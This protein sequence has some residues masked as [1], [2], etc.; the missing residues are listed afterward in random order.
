MIQHCHLPRRLRTPDLGIPAMNHLPGPFVHR[1]SY[2]LLFVYIVFESLSGYS[3]EPIMIFVMA[4]HSAVF[5]E[6]TGQAANFKEST[7]AASQIP[8]FLPISILCHVDCVRISQ[9][10]RQ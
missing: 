5:I 4:V 7:A 8:I 2:T 6:A 1:Q 3:V 9:V 10:S